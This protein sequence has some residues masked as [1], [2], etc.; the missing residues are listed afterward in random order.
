VALLRRGGSQV[1][2]F[3]GTPAEVDA[4]SVAAQAQRLALR[5]EEGG[6]AAIPE[7][8]LRLELGSGS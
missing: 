5:I 2:E 1:A 7:T 3:A 6:L 4:G 8:E